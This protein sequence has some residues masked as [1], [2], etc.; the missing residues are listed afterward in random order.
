MQAAAQQHEAALSTV[1]AEHAQAMEQAKAEA[2]LEITTVSE[3]YEDQV[4]GLQAER[5]QAQA[6][7]AQDK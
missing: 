3:M 5:D 6:T 4:K 1:K 7:A 2:E